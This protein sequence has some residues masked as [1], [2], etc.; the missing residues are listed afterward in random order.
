M[1]ANALKLFTALTLGTASF[2]T[3]QFLLQAEP[4][5]GFGPFFFQSRSI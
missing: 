5:Q 3:S 2:E 1:T 4:T